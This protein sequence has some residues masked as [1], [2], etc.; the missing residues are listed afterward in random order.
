M[1]C[2]EKVAKAT[3]RKT[4]CG[5]GV[6]SFNVRRVLLLKIVRLQ[7]SLKFAR[8]RVQ[9]LPLGESPFLRI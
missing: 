5:Q 2:R 8:E 7:T 3:L 1:T 9:F 4:L 6:K